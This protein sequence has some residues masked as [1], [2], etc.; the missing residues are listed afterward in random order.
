ME[1][2]PAKSDWF[3]ALVPNL[4]PYRVFPSLPGMPLVIFT[5]CQA[6]SPAS[7]EPANGG[8]G[9]TYADQNWLF[10]VQELELNQIKSQPV[11][12]ILE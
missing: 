7:S 6:A 2:S 1:P 11:Y 8:M 3:P 10:L 12:L 5:P 9:E 4:T